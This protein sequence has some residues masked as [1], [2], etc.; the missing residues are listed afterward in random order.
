VRGPVGENTL[1]AEQQ[2]IATLPF[3]RRRASP[4]VHLLDRVVES[5]PA[6]RSRSEYDGR[7]FVGAEKWL[8]GPVLGAGGGLAETVFRLRR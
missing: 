8:S 7:V 2:R 4:G 1:E 6:S 3:V 5:E